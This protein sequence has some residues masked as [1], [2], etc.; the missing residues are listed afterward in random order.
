MQHEN[1]LTVFYVFWF[2]LGSWGG[3][4]WAIQKKCKIVISQQAAWFPKQSD[5]GIFYIKWHFLP[6]PQVF[7]S[8][9]L[10]YNPAPRNTQPAGTF[11]GQTTPVSPSENRCQIHH[12]KGSWRPPH[13]NSEKNRLFRTSQKKQRGFGGGAVCFLIGFELKTKMRDAKSGPG[14]A[15]EDL[16]K[17]VWISE[18]IL[19]LV[20]N[21]QCRPA[22]I[23]SGI[24]DFQVTL[25]SSI[26]APH[27][28][29]KIDY[30]QPFKIFSERRVS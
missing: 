8:C 15:S 24:S 13:Y 28:K 19:N 21:S 12:W 1:Y 11:L 27:H 2:S 23:L 9:L 4:L 18:Q 6:C 14:G 20:S 16:G 7:L 25:Q 29:V 3:E 10:H 5:I 26:T 30:C 22:N 17:G